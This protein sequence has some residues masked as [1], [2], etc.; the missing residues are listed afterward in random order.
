MSK[1][2][3]M[4]DYS[5]DYINI[6]ED[7]RDMGFD[8]M[9]S[10][11]ERNPPEK[12][13]N[14]LTLVPLV[15]RLLESQEETNSMSVAL[16]TLPSLIDPQKKERLGNLIKLLKDGRYKSSQTWWNKLQRDSDVV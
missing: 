14:K 16:H 3:K 11:L 1:I 12:E 13:A 15:D 10:D 2:V 7:L 4:R 8:E 9:I 6:I 5:M